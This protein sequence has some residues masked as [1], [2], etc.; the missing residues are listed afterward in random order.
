VKQDNYVTTTPEKADGIFNLP[1]DK[2]SSAMFLSR[3]DL[4]DDKEG[5]D[6]KALF[7]QT[8]GM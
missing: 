5:L 4:F 1:G 6:T 7:T 8:T 3:N 2:D